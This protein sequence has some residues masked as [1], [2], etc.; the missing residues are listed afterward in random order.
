MSKR[1]E[2]RQFHVNF[3]QAA[4]VEDLDPI[5]KLLYVYMIT[6]PK[7]NMEGVYKTTIKRIAFETGIDKDML[8]KISSRFEA[9]GIGGMMTGSTGA[10][11]IVVSH[12]P[13]F[14]PASPNVKL[15]LNQQIQDWPDELIE[16]MNRVGYRWPNWDDF[17]PPQ[18]NGQATVDQP[19]ATVGD[20]FQRSPTPMQHDT[21]TDTNTIQYNTDTLAPAD[22]SADEVRPLSP[23][24][25]P[26]ANQYQDAF[27]SQTPADAWKSIPQERKHLNDIA[28]RTYRLAHATSRDPTELAASIMEQFAEMKRTGKG[29]YW[30]TAP[31]VPSGLTSRWDAIVEALKKAHEAEEVAIF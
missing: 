3:W 5:E 20:G 10:T 18:S 6:S 25:D 14:M 30:R 9:A 11:W 13:E 23:L 28:K 17:D 4:D 1:G 7:S 12:A 2:F 19:S 26:L 27:T 21:D 24:K 29:D 16:Y 22:A 8:P 15:R 31:F